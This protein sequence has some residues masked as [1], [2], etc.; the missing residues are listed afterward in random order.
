[1]QT[2]SII[3]QLQKL[4]R[5]LNQR[6]R[7]QFGLLLVLMI[8]ASLTEV[9]SISAVLPFLGALTAPERVFNYA[10]AQTFFQYLGISSSTKLLLPLTLAFVAAALLAGCTRLLLLWAS[11]RLT[12]AVGADLSFS[13]YQRTLY[14][15]Y[16]VHLARNSSEVIAGITTKVSIVTHNLF[17]L[18][19][20]LSSC[21]LML[22]IVTALLFIDPIVA[23]SAMVGFFCIYALI[24]FITRNRA[25][26]NSYRIS[27]NSSEVIKALQE[28]LGGIRDV[29]IDG[30]QA[31][32][33]KIYRD[34][35]LSLRQAQGSNAFIYSSPRIGVETLSMLLI[36]TLA[37][38]LSNDEAG[39]SK[40]IPVLG[41]LALGA[42]KML[43][44][45][46]QIY[47]GWASLRGDHASIKDT[48][49]LL[50]Q[51]LPESSYLAAQSMISFNKSISL[52][53]VGYRYSPQSAWIF[54]DLS[55]VIPKG[56]RV[57]FVGKTGSGKTT[58]LDIVMSLLLPTE[59][60]LN[61]DDQTI[62]AANHR[63]WQ[64]HIAHV[65]QAIYLADSTIAENIAFGVPKDNIDYFRVRQAAQQAKISETIE[66]L[67]LQ[68]N[69]F[70]GERGIRLSGGQRQRIGIAR[71]LYKKANVIV[72]DE[73]TSAL[74]SNTEEEVM[75]AIESLS[76][77]ITILI[78]A[79]RISTL[80]NCNQI[81]E[82]NN[83]FINYIKSG[84]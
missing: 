58:L 47:S 26:A 60:T 35:D 64:A 72:F 17:Q 15:P 40:A 39:F 67:P 2:D 9:L 31:T 19:N 68:Y 77:N 73:A 33:C 61:V 5:H 79:H 80:K 42:Q 63:N 8:F 50:N 65:P 16:E 52:N 22:S 44:A 62:T 21:V 34:A 56:S 23:T 7:G 55:I 81:L 36:A 29:L 48:V 78:I 13:I 74:D 82:L 1:V 10:I 4:W 12:Y 76:E 11:V 38:A 18:L 53:K 41:G 84:V 83:G 6:R 28:G 66:S 14:Q 59:G 46:Q 25:H 32:Y 70:V 51:S 57:G 24:I 71:A 75:D 30:S 43:P 54:R 45:M 49:D 27:R 69:S 3:S 37:Y 20:L